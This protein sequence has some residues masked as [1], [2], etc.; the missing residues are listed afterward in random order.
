[1]QYRGY[2]IALECVIL[3]AIFSLHKWHKSGT[4]VL[5]YLGGCSLRAKL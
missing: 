1:M 3:F 5:E 2:S 4:V